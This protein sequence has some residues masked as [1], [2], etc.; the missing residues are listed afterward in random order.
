MSVLLATAF[1]VQFVS[2]LSGAN[3]GPDQ[4]ERWFQS[5]NTPEDS[6]DAAF[7]AVWRGY[8]IL[9]DCYVD[10]PDGRRLLAAAWNNALRAAATARAEPDEPLGEPDSDLAAIEA[11]F[12]SAMR[13]LME[14]AGPGIAPLELAQAAISGMTLSLADN[15]TAFRRLDN[16]LDL[17]LPLS[18]QRPDFGFSSIGVIGGSLVWEVQADGPAAL[19]GIAVGD[20]I[21]SVRILSESGNGPTAVGVPMVLGV[22]R[23]GVGKIQVRLIPRADEPSLE[24]S[25]SPDG[26]ARLRLR[27][28]RITAAQFLERYS[29]QLDAMEQGCPKGWV[30]DLRNNSGGRLDL[31]EI[32]AQKLGYAGRL[33][34]A[35]PRY[36]S[37]PEVEPT[38]VRS[39]THYLPLVILVNGRS[40]SASE[41]IA[42][43]LQDAGMAYVVGTMTPGS[44]NLSR[45]F[46][47]ARGELSVTVA[48]A[49]VGPF[50]RNLDG[51]GVTP[52]ET[53]EMDRRSLIEGRDPQMER[54]NRYILESASR[55]EAC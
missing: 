38:P 43:A 45:T 26:V 54:A 24:S 29:S 9:L 4:C 41:V 39:I 40:A 16:Y 12:E 46:V 32:V 13:H 51:V 22:D 23:S 30:L 44:V 5:G 34:L 15:H 14:Q 35:R 47:V 31:A 3:Q 1:G 17:Q 49:L 36:A 2:P 55:A 21:V 19:A 27:S 7:R 33:I 10:P 6:E 52:N 25:L 48:R 11:R 42:A 20:V 8:Q 53:I 50:Q 37:L 18:R 28:F